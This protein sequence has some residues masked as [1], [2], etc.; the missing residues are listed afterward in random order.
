[1]TK[2]RTGASPSGCPVASSGSQRAKNASCSSKYR[3]T[4]QTLSGPKSTSWQKVASPRI[5][6]WLHGPT[7]SRCGVAFCAAI[8]A[9]Y[10][11]SAAGNGSYQPV[12]YVPGTSACRCQW[13]VKSFSIRAQYSSYA[14][15]VE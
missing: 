4:P 3:R 5:P 10:S 1:M 2:I 12:E 6:T 8:A 11:E 9:K 13:R 15:R 14:P 7:T